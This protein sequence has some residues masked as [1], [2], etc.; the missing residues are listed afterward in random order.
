MFMLPTPLNLTY[1]I[2]LY[3]RYF[4]VLN[5]NISFV[6]SNVPS[7]IDDLMTREPLERATKEYL[8]EYI[9]KTSPIS[10]FALTS[11]E[12]LF[13]EPL[14]ST[15][16]SRTGKM[17]RSLAPAGLRQSRQNETIGEDERIHLQVIL[18]LQGFKIYP[19][20][21]VLT[22]LLLEAVDSP[23]YTAELRQSDSF[24]A[25]A[26]ASSAAQAKPR[27][28]KEPPPPEDK[29]VS[30]VTVIV[31]TTIIASLVIFGAVLYKKQA[32]AREKSNRE[33]PVSAETPQYSTGS[34][35][36]NVFSFDLSPASSTGLGRLLSV[37]SGDS[38]GSTS[39]SSSQEISPS[40][41]KQKV[42]EHPLTGII[43]PMVV[44]ENIEES[45]PDTS[46]RILPET[47]DAKKKVVVPTKRMEASAS[48]IEALN[49]SQNG[50]PG[51]SSSFPEL[52]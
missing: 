47:T 9:L 32:R 40:P 16:S 39:P 6:I 41:R 43:P 35:R 4:T 50:Q 31:I 52:M 29:K 15:I 21:I 12:L 46:M 22:D 5:T 33:L 17:P 20:K 34:L 2:A 37:F 19:I 14:N 49:N 7:L 30:T 11:V 45:D 13:Q 42:E 36:A 1:L 10:K 38:R 18:N 3:Y 8:T 48:F 51:S 44:I 28:V 23:E 27:V 26:T 24:Y 25:N